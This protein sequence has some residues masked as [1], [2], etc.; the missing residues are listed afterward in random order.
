MN[1][2]LQ[3]YE[4][5]LTDPGFMGDPLQL[6]VVERLDL[7]FHE[8]QCSTNRF[9]RKRRPVKGLYLWGGVGRGKTFLMDL[10]FE[11]LPDKDKLRLHFH[12]FMAMVHHEMKLEAGHADPLVRIAKRLSQ[13]CRVICFD[14][15]YVSDIADA[16]IL[17]RLFDAL[18]NYGLTLVATSNIPI[19][20][21]YWDGLQRQRFA[22]AMELLK[23]HTQEWHLNG[24]EDYRLRYLNY[25][26]T[27]FLEGQANFAE[28][29]DQL[30]ETQDYS[31]QPISICARPIGV[32]RA[33]N[34]IVW[35]TFSALCEGPR[36]AMDYIELASRYQT[37]LISGLPQL[38]G[39]LKSWIKARGTED[40]SGSVTKTGERQLSYA[41]LDDPARRFISLVDEFYDQRVKLYLLATLPIEHIYSGGALSFEFRRTLSRLTEMQS[42]EYLSGSRKLNKSEQVVG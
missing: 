20:R 9:G 39:E 17:G 6:Q 3:R 35:F 15:F 41:K 28:L 40:G 27:Y 13:Q 33:A 25:Q 22:P 18:F 42:A 19:D 36:S 8:L 7:L 10:F 5:R 16:M 30:S 38:G 32:E 21:L 11:S 4:Q 24:E 34:S 23:T 14:E 29:F 1:S 12:R 26:Q 2:P 37:I 31:C